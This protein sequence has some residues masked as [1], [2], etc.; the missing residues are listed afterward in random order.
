[1]PARSAPDQVTN[2]IGLQRRAGGWEGRQS[3]V[4]HPHA[5][6]ELWRWMDEVERTEALIQ[7][8]R[9]LLA[10]AEAACASA[11]EV[12]LSSEHILHI[13]RVIPVTR[14]RRKAINHGP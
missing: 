7:R 4:N 6:Q 5:A 2:V 8:N 10:R 12:V 1:M 9:E 11:Q 13:L 3:S 14:E